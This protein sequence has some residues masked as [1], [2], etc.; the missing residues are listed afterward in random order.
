M[1]QPLSGKAGELL[2]GSSNLIQLTQWELEYGSEIEVYTARS[3]NGTEE[4][5]DGI[6]GG[7]GSFELM[8][9]PGGPIT[10]L[11]SPGDL[12]TMK[13]RHTATGPVEADGQARLGRFTYGANRDGTGQRVTVTFTC[14]GSWTFPS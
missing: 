8:Y 4:T 13:C 7:T 6:I 14:H 3:G 10:S 11:V 9:D 2:I 12:V 5:I 1:G